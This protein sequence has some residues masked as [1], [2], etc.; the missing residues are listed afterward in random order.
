MRWVGKLAGFGYTMA[1]Q[2]YLPFYYV[3]FV[4][5]LLSVSVL[6]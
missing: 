2:G 4:Y 3:I 5:E 1:I 6:K